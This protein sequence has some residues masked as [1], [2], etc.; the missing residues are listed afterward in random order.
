MKQL[1]KRLKVT[2]TL[3]LL[4][5]IALLLFASLLQSFRT[6]LLVVRSLFS[7]SFSLFQALSGRA[8]AQRVQRKAHV[9]DAGWPLAS[10]STAAGCQQSSKE[11]QLSK[12]KAHGEDRGLTIEVPPGLLTLLT[13]LNAPIGRPCELCGKEFSAVLE[14]LHQHFAHFFAHSVPVQE[15]GGLFKVRV[16]PG[17][18]YIY[19]IYHTVRVQRIC[20]HTMR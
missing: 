8:P 1:A 6:S 13:L 15:L 20:L 14:V 7:A 3:G 12:Q 11:E 17:A 9:P 19:H 18:F 10:K 2:H 16:A 4:M 5:D